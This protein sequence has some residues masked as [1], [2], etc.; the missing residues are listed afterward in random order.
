MKMMHIATLALVVLMSCKPKVDK[1]DSTVATDHT[2]HTEAVSTPASTAVPAPPAPDPAVSGT[3]EKTVLKGTEV[4]PATPAKPVTSDVKQKVK[5]PPATTTTVSTPAP[6][7]AAPAVAPPPPPTVQKPTTS[8]ST[9]VVE[10]PANAKPAPPINSE[11][12]PPT[13]TK[14][15]KPVPKVKIKGSPTHKEWDG[16]LTA[17]VSAAGVVDYKGLKGK[18]DVLD[19]YLATLATLAP[20]PSWSSEEK[21]AYWINL[22]NAATVKLILKN[23]PLKSIT[24]L[25]GGKPWDVKWVKSGDKTYSLN[26]IENDI[27]RPRFNEPRIHFAV[28]CAAISCPP[29]ANQAFT[30]KNLESLMT[31]QTKAFINNAKYNTLSK[32]AITISKIFDWYGEDFGNVSTFVARYADSSV[33]P[34]AEVSY[35]EYDWAL[36]GK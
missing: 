35:S 29:L 8:T 28:N 22:Y 20:Q 25:H 13:N 9:V 31:K 14:P 18:E 30:P 6:E 17:H 19:A 23:Y 1:Q 16:L 33:S 27:I 11:P 7:Q 5:T 4:E 15:V 32:N 24:N 2:E 12:A 26:N 3:V 21:L 34:T 36:N 10:K